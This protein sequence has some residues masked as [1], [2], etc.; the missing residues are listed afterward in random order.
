M[1]EKDIS[2]LRVQSLSP[3]KGNEEIPAGLSA[4]MGGHVTPAVHVTR[5]AYSEKA[6]PGAED[7]RD[8]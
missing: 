2:S 5:P 3:V 4:I 6:S 1:L 7:A 8:V